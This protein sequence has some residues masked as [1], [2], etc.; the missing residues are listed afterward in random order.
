MMKRIENNQ[1]IEE[2]LRRY[3]EEPNYHDGFSDGLNGNFL[4]NGCSI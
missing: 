3:F 4:C 2:K 1:E